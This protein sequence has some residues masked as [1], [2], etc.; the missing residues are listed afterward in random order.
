[1]A[2]ARQ[3]ERTLPQAAYLVPATLAVALVLG[4]I[5]AFGMIAAPSIDLG[6][7]GTD[8][9]ATVIQSGQDWEAQRQ[10]QSGYTD[11]LTQ[12]GQDWE[13]QREQQS[14][15]DPVIQSGKD[16]DAQREQQSG[17]TPR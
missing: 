4:V 14:I 6:S 9:S 12:S 17:T 7:L 3:A 10:Q 8:T 5:L 1:M 15:S 16:W 13:A 11:P 2:Q